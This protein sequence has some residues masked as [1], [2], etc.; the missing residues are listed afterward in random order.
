MNPTER[1]KLLA[2]LFGIIFLGSIVYLFFEGH[3]E[4]EADAKQKETLGKPAAVKGKAPAE[5][6]AHCPICGKELPS[7]GECP[8]CL[9]KKLEKSGGKDEPA[10]VPRLGR[11]LAWSMVG[12]T[13]VLGAVHLGMFLR[14]RRRFLGTGG[15]EDQLKTR[16][17]HCKRRVR[18][19][20]RLAGSYG[21]CPTCRQRIRFD[22]VSDPYG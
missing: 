21:S 2:G 4:E 16:C 11:Y 14:Q 20:A 19:A 22:P 6:H 18:F 17:I 3:S 9:I 10:P 5:E 1:V 8:F 13:V 15:E 12:A 7:S